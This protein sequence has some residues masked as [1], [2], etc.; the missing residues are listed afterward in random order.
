MNSEK[1]DRNQFDAERE[2]KVAISSTWTAVDSRLRVDQL[3]PSAL[4]Y[5]GDAV[6]ELFIRSHFLLP[7]KRI[8]DYHNLVVA[9]VRAES[10]A[11]CLTLLEPHLSDLEREV[12]RRGRNATTKCPSRLP[13]QIYQQ[14]TGFEALL[15]YLYVGHPQR[16]NQLLKQLELQ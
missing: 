14:A 12:V 4:A 16:L 9:Q 1:R 7:P 8:S 15:G 13:P 10:Q 2:A 3:S 11:A 5:L 6:Y